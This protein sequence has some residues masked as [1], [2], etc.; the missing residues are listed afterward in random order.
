[1][2]LRAGL[3]CAHLQQ[4]LPVTVCPA[5]V[6]VSPPSQGSS[7]CFQTDRSLRVCSTPV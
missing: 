7:L 3:P 5:R 1:M 2:V 4:G 6:M